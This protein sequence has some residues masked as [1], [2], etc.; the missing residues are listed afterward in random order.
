MKRSE[1]KRGAST[2]K[3]TALKRSDSTLKRSKLNPMSDKRKKVN[4]ERTKKMREH[5]GPSST[6]RCTVKNNVAMLA[7]M[8]RCRGEVHGHELLSRSRA[9]RTDV[10]LL[11]MDGIILLCDFHNGWVEDNPKKAHDFGLTLHAW[12]KS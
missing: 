4:A 3:R 11:D 7:E 6:W 12:E 9:G 5:F 1:L 8:G 10:N 2:L